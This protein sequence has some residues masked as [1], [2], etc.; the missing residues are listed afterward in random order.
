MRT[1]QALS[2]LAIV[3]L[4]ASGCATQPMAKLGSASFANADNRTPANLFAPSPS[5]QD[6]PLNR[7]NLAAVYG[8]TGRMAEAAALYTTVVADGQFTNIATN[9]VTNN[10]V[11]E[12]SQIN[13][14]DEARRRLV[15]MKVPI[16][17]AAI[18][19]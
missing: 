18:G 19:G 6:S 11:G 1:L 8:S 2:C 4:L 15:M 7:F 13:L 9:R 12:S 3:G 17:E 14:A 10:R 16:V 5:A